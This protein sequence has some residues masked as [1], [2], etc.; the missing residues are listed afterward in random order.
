MATSKINKSV[1]SILKYYLL[2][3]S[4]ASFLLTYVLIKEGV[5]GIENKIFSIKLQVSNDNNK[6]IELKSKINELEL[7]SSIE[8][9]AS[10]L[11][12]MDKEALII[13]VSR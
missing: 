5:A 3:F 12:F 9:K 11:G 2:I 10:E 8:Q 4:I 6:I 13:K 1:N 7:R